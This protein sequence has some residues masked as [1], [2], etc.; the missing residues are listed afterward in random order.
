MMGNNDG[1]AFG[2]RAILAK[3]RRRS[4]ARRAPYLAIVSWLALAACDADR[5][6]LQ[7][8]ASAADAEFVGGA[9]CGE[10]HADEVA[11]WAGS[12]HDLAMQPA[13]AASILADFDD[14]EFTYAG[15]TTRF[16]RRDDEFRVSTDGT[17]GEI[18]EFTVTHSFGVEPLQQYLVAFDDG[19]R[20]ALGVAWDTR[21]AEAGGQ[22]WFHLHADDEVDH[23]DPLHW[24]GIYQNWNTMCADCH[25]TDLAKGYALDSDAFATTF[26]SVDVDCEACHGPSSLHIENP[27]VPPPAAGGEDHTWVFDPGA[28]IAA[29]R[30]AAATDGGAGFGGQ[31][32]TCARCH[33][34]RTQL[35][36]NFV[37]GD[38]LLDG[39][40]PELLIEGLYHADGQILDE[41][42]VYG[43]FVQSAMAHAGVVCSDCHDPHSA[44]LVA[45]GNALCGQCHLASVFDQPAHHRHEGGT[46]A[47]ECTSCHMR[48]ETYMQVDPR[49]DHSFRVPR[50][51]LT[52]ET[53]SP[54]ACND[55]HADETPEWATVR[56]AEWFPDGRSTE[57]HFGQAL[58]AART[59]R[60]DARERLV[61]LIENPEE[62]G[63]ARA[64]AVRLLAG[65]M[66][67]GDIAVVGRALDQD[68]PLLVLAAIEAVADIARERRVELVQRFL[69]DDRLAL[70][71]A[72]AR[73]LVTAQELLSPRRQADLAAAI[74]DYLAIQAFN[75]DRPE[76]LLNA[77]TLA[78]DQGLYD[79]A[80]LLYT[81]AIERYPYYA[82]LYVN[83]ADLHRLEGRPD[84]AEATLR[85]GLEA[86]PDR[87]G[88]RLA[89]GFAL[90]REGRAA[91]ALAE[92]RRAVELVPDEPYYRYVLAVA[93]NDNGDSEAALAQ[94]KA[95]HERFPGYR[96]P[97]FA[98][99]TM[100]RDAG[101]FEAAAD[102]AARLVDLMPDDSAARSLLR[103]LEQRL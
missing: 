64:T 100:L 2:I 32:E 19:R 92:F 48:A 1:M 95:T 63:I 52:V 78:I 93:E 33:S 27:S 71:A 61:A 4:V 73:S 101:D 35:T 53:G 65:R 42:Y 46:R 44:D 88:L 69:T 5:D 62:P 77:G 37:A 28:S 91:E 87:S 31:V 54:N 14:A 80:E 29:R 38:A 36:D 55:C 83:L 76:G 85:A 72:A 59:Y 24:T 49:R 26:G 51:D 3:H 10:C 58:H 11:A 79:D 81:T 66:A 94:L 18:A 90:V 68:E 34:R 60:A 67:P 41:V 43:S 50:P 103:A 98:L 8:V 12:H 7:A 96:E 6:N 70:R 47:A 45:E 99:A 89:L 17:D 13:D 86:S 97:L 82:A 39:Y 56:V 25:S 23:A 30:P 84:A 40:R 20:Q 21:P 16:F 75:S 74:E 9:A 57:P 102:Y 22:R 15:V